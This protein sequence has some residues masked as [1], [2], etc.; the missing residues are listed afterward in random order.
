M[1]FNFK[2]NINDYNIDVNVVANLDESNNKKKVKKIIDK[3]MTTFSKIANNWYI[4]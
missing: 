4:N 2:F 3:S 1:S